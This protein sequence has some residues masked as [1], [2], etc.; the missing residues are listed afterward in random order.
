MTEA[1]ESLVVPD[2]DSR[3]VTPAVA[4][5]QYRKAVDSAGEGDIVWAQ[6]MIFHF[7][8][9]SMAPLV[10]AWRE[11]AER[12]AVVHLTRDAISIQVSYDGRQRPV[13]GRDSGI[14]KEVRRRE[15]KI[16][17]DELIHPNIHIT[18]LK[19]PIIVPP[20]FPVG[21]NHIKGYG[22]LLHEG[23]SVGYLPTHNLDDASIIVDRNLAG[24]FTK[25]DQVR[26]LFDVAGLTHSVSPDG[27]RIR[28]R[29]RDF[30]IDFGDD[31]DL[32]VDVGRPLQSSIYKRSIDMLEDRNPDRIIF[33][34]QFP[35]DPYMLRKLAR[36]ARN[37]SRIDFYTTADMH[38]M[39]SPHHMR[40]L[41][42]AVNRAARTLDTFNVHRLPEDL[43]HIKALTIQTGNRVVEASFGT[44]N[45]FYPIVAF[46]TAE[47]QVISRNN[48]FNTHLVEEIEK[49]AAGY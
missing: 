13:S 6:A 10:P 47:M 3:I 30:V 2:R 29:S 5:E 23:G 26:K 31:M 48:T 4:L 8:S 28:M 22:V 21:R 11:A 20:T 19:P 7:G 9:V 17:S 27:S 34:S 1:R 44:H 12:G 25:K 42:K 14:Y 33:A 45:L 49:A 18:T 41:N 36:H 40:A 39:N 37:G 46:G 38:H 35:P 32:I 16:I 15:E 43:M 24:E